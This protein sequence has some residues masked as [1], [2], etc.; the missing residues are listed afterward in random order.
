MWQMVLLVLVDD[1]QLPAVVEAWTEAGVS[2]ITTLPSAGTVQLLD[3]CRRDDL[4]LFPSLDDVLEQGE[5]QH[6]TLFTVVEGDTMVD[7][8]V[9]AT[10]AVLGDLDEPGR[11]ILFTVPLGRV[12]GVRG[13]R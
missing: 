2:G 3:R 13:V 4:P 8:L 5:A 7:L 9:A 12:R 10:E 6:Q 1:Q 11:G